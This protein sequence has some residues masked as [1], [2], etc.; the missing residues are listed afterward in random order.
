M[1]LDRP[2]RSI[3]LSDDDVWLVPRFIGS[4][5]TQE[6]NFRRTQITHLFVLWLTFHIVELV[7]QLPAVRQ[8]NSEP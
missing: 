8:E 2:T 7:S 6:T 4:T 3:R 5:L 1:S